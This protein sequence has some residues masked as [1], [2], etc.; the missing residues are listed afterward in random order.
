MFSS[1]ADQYDL[2]NTLLSAN[3]DRAWRKFTANCAK[4]G[5][6]IGLDV[7]TGTGKLAQ[8]LLEASL[9]DGQVIGIDFCEDMVKIAKQNVDGIGFLLGDAE[10][11]PFP[12]NT[13]DCATIGFSMR[14]VNSISKTFG[15]M[16][17]VVRSEGKVVC[18]EFSPPPPGL[19]GKAYTLYIKTVLPFLGWII[20]RN[21]DAYTYLPQSILAFHNPE[22][23]KQIMVSV[24]LRDVKYHRLSFGIVYVHEGTK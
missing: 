4:P 9:D 10:S 24:G 12:D 23:L 20:A 15:E 16:T 22:E 14:N 13:F 21:R 17:R 3:R 18:L 2:L 6:G 1:I 11:L 5:S 7:A 8:D 19:K